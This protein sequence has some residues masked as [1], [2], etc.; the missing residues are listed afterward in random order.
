[1]NLFC[2]KC[3]HL[4]FGADACPNCA[5]RA[6]A[7]AVRGEV[8]WTGDLTAALPEYCHPAL[9][10]ERLCI[11]ADRQYV[12]SISA[13]PEALSFYLIGYHWGY[14]QSLVAFGFASGK[15]RGSLPR[16]T[17]TTFMMFTPISG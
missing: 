10:G 6:P 3:D 9:A 17:Y 5:W 1:M 14:G 12:L 7:P 15:V 16:H 11:P 8:V 13:K 2:P 4:I